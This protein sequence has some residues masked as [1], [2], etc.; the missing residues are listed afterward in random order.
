MA[1]S[2]EDVLDKLQD[3]SNYLVVIDTSKE[4]FLDEDDEREPVEF[5][6]YEELLSEKK[7]KILANVDDET[8]YISVPPES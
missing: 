6:I 7:I 3:Q 5:G 2:K 1:L 8:M 4:C